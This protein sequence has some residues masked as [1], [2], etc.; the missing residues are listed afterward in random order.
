MAENK[1]ANL[2]ALKENGVMQMRDPELFSIRL[3][4]VGGRL[5][6]AQMQAVGEAAAKYGRGEAHLTTRQGVEIPYVPFASIDALRADLARAGLEFGRCGARVRTI[7]ACLGMACRFGLIDSQGLAKTLFARANR[8]TS[9]PHKFKIA[10]TGCPNSCAKPQENDF[11]VMGLARK[12]F[13]PALC[14]ACALCLKACRIPGALTMEGDHP[15]CVGGL[16]VEC[17]KC[18][19]ACP[20][21]A[22]EIVGSGY[23]VYVG[24]KVGRVPRAARRLPFEIADQAALLHSLDGI[25]DWYC[26]Q[27]KP[28]ERFGDTIERVGFDALVAHL[29]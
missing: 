4:V 11:G 22:W 17:G 27:G 13:H 26:A 21:N 16:C 10:V 7:V 29:E 18:A 8:Y 25:V 28:A 5:T 23:A 3:L 14:T 2:K 1:L 12:V 19:P 9:L 15:F 24:G 6:A 20:T